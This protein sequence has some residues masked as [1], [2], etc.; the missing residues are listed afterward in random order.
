M[1]QATR[2][3]RFREDLFYRLNVCHLRPPSLRERLEDFEDLLYGFARQYRVRFSFNAI[4]TLKQHPW[5][6]N[7][8]ELKNMVARASAYYPGALIQ[9]DD[10]TAILEPVTGTDAYGLE[11][12]RSQGSI[13]KE[14]EREIIVR[15]LV[16]NQGNQRRTA[17]DLGMAK[18][19]LHDR[20][21]HYSIDVKQISEVKA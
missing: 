5:S 20:I 17:K 3:G 10:L 21:R 14:L 1:I 16:A 4:A 18:S 12:M 19:T 11:P 13:I 2:D 8:R 7:I 6:G 9:P 15:R